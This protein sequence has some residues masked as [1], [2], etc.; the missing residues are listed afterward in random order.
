M[1]LQ[2]VYLCLYLDSYHFNLCLKGHPS[3]TLRI[4][5]PN[6]VAYLD[7]TGSGC[8]TISHIY[9]NGRVTVMFN[10]F[11]SSPRILR[12][13]S[14]GEVA[15][16]GSMK[17]NELITLFKD[18]KHETGEEEEQKND[19]NHD[20]DWQ[21]DALLSGSRA[22]ILLHVFKVQTSCGYGVP[23]MNK[24]PKDDADENVSSLP[25]SDRVTMPNWANAKS[26]DQLL[27]YRVKNNV[28]SLD[29]LPGLTAARRDNTEWIGVAEVSSWL[30]RVFWAQLESLLMGMLLVLVILGIGRS[31]EP[32]LL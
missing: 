24:V 10:S 20:G 28:R 3:R 19:K 15:E 12:L 23:R 1:S 18:D 22:I 7:S 27:E 30:R 5:S 9:E 26:M 31:I 25:W 8:E 11:G 16:R 2:K 17:Y 32:R 6:L 29:G 21:L 4:L 14:R 13:F